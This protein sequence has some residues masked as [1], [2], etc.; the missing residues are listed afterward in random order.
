[1]TLNDS[2]ASHPVRTTIKVVAEKNDTMTDSA[3]C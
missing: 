1:M 2:R 3:S